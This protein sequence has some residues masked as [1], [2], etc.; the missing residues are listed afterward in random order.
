MSKPCA[1][2]FTQL[3][4]KTGHD[5]TNYKRATILRRIERRMNVREMAD[6]PAYATFIHADKEE[7]QILLKELLISVTNF[8]R[9][10]PAF[11]ALEARVLPKIFAGKGPEDAVRIWVSACATGEEA[12]SL[13]IL[14][15]RAA[16]GHIGAAHATDIRD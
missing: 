4:I 2:S 10:R 12:Y 14:W 6:L 15:R 1:T 7:P 3:R 16:G 13:A 11:E 9:D 8:F 5:F